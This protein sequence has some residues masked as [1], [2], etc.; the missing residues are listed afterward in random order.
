MASKPIWEKKNPKKKS[1]PLTSA[2]K[3]AA[4]SRA[5]SAGRKYPNMVDNAWAARR[6]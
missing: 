2:Q 6:G 3:T 1:K 5:K 4:K